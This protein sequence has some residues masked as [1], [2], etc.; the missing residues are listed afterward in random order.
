MA[1]Q[2]QSSNIVK[3]A[4]LEELVQL[5][6]QEAQQQGATGAEATINSEHGLSVTARLGEIET[7]EHHNDR[8]LGITLYFGQNKGTSSTSSFDPLAIKDAVSAAADIAKFTQADQCNG[9]ADVNRMPTRIMDLDLDHPWAISPEEALEIALDCENSAREHEQISNSEGANVATSRTSSI[10]ANTHGFTGRYTS[11]RHTLSCVVVAEKNGSMQRDYWFTTSRN[12]ANLES[13]SIVGKKSAERALARLGAKKISTRTTPVIFEANMARSLLSHFVTA[14][15]GG[16]L[17]RKAS[18]LIDQLDKKVFSDL[19]TITDDPH[20]QQGLGS[21][22]YDLEGVATEPRTIVDNGILKS[23]VLSS[24]SARRLGMES[25]GNAGGIHNLKLQA[26]TQSLDELMQKMQQ[27]LL[28]TE[29]IG[30]GVNNVTGDYSRGAVG[31]WIENGKIQYPVEE[32]TIAGNLKQ[33]FQKI[34]ATGSDLDER[35]NIITPS[36]LIDD[37]MI[38]GS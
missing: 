10:Y 7:L 32:I 34:I 6:L 4:N 5:C 22:V 9:L 26:G 24:Y 14:I 27:G 3:E 36:I 12:P 18:F 17:Y 37:M 33:M 8:A 38:A 15:S 19:V 16:A 29:L 2:K 31:Y 1:L 28:V 25:T 21:S 13:S 23:Y 20:I 30:H 35:S 11:T